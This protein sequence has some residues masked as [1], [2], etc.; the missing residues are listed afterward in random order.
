MGRWSAFLCQEFLG[1][2]Q[3][4]ALPLAGRRRVPHW[5]APSQPPNPLQK[6]QLWL[7]CSRSCTGSCLQSS[8]LASVCVLS[9]GTAKGL[10]YDSRERQKALVTRGFHSGL[11]TLSRPWLVSSRRLL[12]RKVGAW[13][14]GYVLAGS[15]T[16]SGSQVQPQGLKHTLFIPVSEEAV[17]KLSFSWV[18]DLQC[19]HPFLKHLFLVPLSPFLLHLD[20]YSLFNSKSLYE[21]S[22]LN[23]QFESKQI[24]DFLGGPVVK[25]PPCNAGDAGLI[26]GSGN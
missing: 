14:R 22:S 7:P 4:P 12:P 20:Q 26:P 15:A 16:L 8:R 18:A 2:Y 10:E 6:Q 3:L 25:S 1:Y 24:R 21:T 19:P 23:K 11:T 17:R 5:A 13:R 9:W